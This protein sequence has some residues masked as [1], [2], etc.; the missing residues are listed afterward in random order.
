M[1]W[2]FVPSP[3]DRDTGCHFVPGPVDMEAASKKTT[4]AAADEP[5]WIIPWKTSTP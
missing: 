2:L 4:E 1:T 3:I 5:V